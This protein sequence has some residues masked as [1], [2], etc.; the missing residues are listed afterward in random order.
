MNIE[1][2]GTISNRRKAIQKSS[3]TGY[4]IITA[5]P[6]R[7]IMSMAEEMGMSIP[8]PIQIKLSGDLGRALGLGPV[9]IDD[10]GPIL[11]ACSLEVDTLH[12]TLNDQVSVCINS[13]EG[14]MGIL[15][16]MTINRGC[17][18]DS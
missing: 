3:L 10:I 16:A 14:T 8:E 1:I 12:C 11:K 7:D 4:R 17:G 2:G 9:I 6:V 5:Y 13:T 18:D 15:S